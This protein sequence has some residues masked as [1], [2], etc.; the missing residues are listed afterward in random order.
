MLYNTLSAFPVTIT[1]CDNPSS[2]EE[3]EFSEEELAEIVKNNG[4][5]KKP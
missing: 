2:K 3:Y 5:I 1:S 4:F